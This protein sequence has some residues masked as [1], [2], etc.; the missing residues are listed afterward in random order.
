MIKESIDFFNKV[1][2]AELYLARLKR[3]NLKEYTQLRTE[4]ILHE[5]DDL[6]FS[7]YDCLFAEEVKLARYVMDNI[8]VSN[9]ESD[10]DA[11]LSKVKGKKLRFWWDL[12]RGEPVVEESEELLYL[13]YFTL[14]AG[15]SGT[16]VDISRLEDLSYVAG[17]FIR[18]KMIGKMMTLSPFEHT[19]PYFMNVVRLGDAQKILLEQSNSFLTQR[20]NTL[21][22][23]SDER[24]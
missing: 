23:N 11:G 3:H 7:I 2:R 1:N 14:C 22:G 9:I 24:E 21:G 6:D 20:I 13:N 4:A 10:L 12:F 18:E 8:D 15:R 19:K 5:I 17:Q 16:N